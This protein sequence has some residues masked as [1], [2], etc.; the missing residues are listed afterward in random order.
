M[1]TIGEKQIEKRTEYEVELVKKK[2]GGKIIGLSW[3][4]KQNITQ[5][6]VDIYIK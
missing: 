3:W 4:E 5:V 2:S 6:G 1:K